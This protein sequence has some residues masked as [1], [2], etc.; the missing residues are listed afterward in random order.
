[1]VDDLDTKQ[2]T[3]EL[4]AKYPNAGIEHIEVDQSTGQ[5]T[6]ML[7]PTKQNL[8]FSDKAGVA[9]KPHVFSEAGSTMNRDF[10]TRQ[11]LDLASPKSPYEEDSKELFKI[12]DK[13]YY[14]DPLVGSVTNILSSLSMKGFEND[15][16]DENIKQFYDSWSLDVNL[17]EVIE[18]IFLDFFKI[19]HV[20][21]Y[22]A[23]GKY[24][25]QIS[26]LS[27]VPGKK[28]KVSKTKA[29]QIRLNKLHASFEEEREKEIR[30]EVETAKANGCSKKEV[31]EIE[32]SAKKNIWSKG[33]LP[34]SYTVLNPQIVNIE[35]NLLFNNVSVKLTPPPEFKKL[36][37]KEK[38]ELTEEEK[39]LIKMLPN[40][41]KKVAEGGG[42]YQLDSR[43]VNFVTYRKQ[44]Y[45]RYARPRSTRTFETINYKQQLKNADLSTLDGIT[46]Y[47]LKI[48][49]GNDDYPVTSQTELETVAKLFDTP[50]KSFD[51]IWN[52]TLSIEKIVSPEIESI[53]GQ[54]KY[55]Q[56]NEDMTAGLAV[57]RA[58]VD[59]TGDINTAEVSLLT[60]GIME[61]VNYARRQVEKWIYKEYRQIAEAMG[62][63]RFPKVR[64]DDSVLRDK[65]LYMKTIASL[66]DR[67]MLS[68]KTSLE[69]L[70]FDYDNELSNMKD[71]VSLV[72]D[73]TFGILGSPWQKSATQPVQNSP[74]GTPSDGR[75]AG[76]TNTPNTDEGNINIIKNMSDLEFSSFLDGAREV[77]SNEKYAKFLNEVGKIRHG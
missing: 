58:I 28:T 48:T 32:K 10:M 35:G 14:S 18:W 22:K 64:W 36:L 37:N 59:G 55:K 74:Q 70:G 60:K 30:H 49:I 72:E 76:Q 11:T 8:A 68:Y 61:E 1:M 75:P 24:E 4:K 69:A 33:H 50:S 56:V 65:T 66:V 67:R 3:D 54:D 15:I 46:N 57:T 34:L 53:L 51:V 31:K 21:T 2:L 44:P 25:P 39:N 13:Y 20:T 62:F 23:I 19:G 29:E 42:E 63:D 16:D 38:S 17:E 71:E 77:L 73:G 26:N 27:Q 41:L 40:E 45:E 12:A 47:I 52:H 7:R 9:V 5:S 43:L 6:F